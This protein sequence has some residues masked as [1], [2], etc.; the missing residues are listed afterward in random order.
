MCGLRG[1]S[2][3]GPHGS[4][5]YQISLEHPHMIVFPSSENQEIFLCNK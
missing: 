1:I 2:E 4:N 5:M 3:T